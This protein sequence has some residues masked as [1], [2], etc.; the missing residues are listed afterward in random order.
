MQELCETILSYSILLKR[1]DRDGLSV[2]A[3][4]QHC[5]QFLYETLGERVDFDIPDALAKL[6][7]L[8]LAHSDGGG[9]TATRLALAPRVLA[10]NWRELLDSRKMQD[11]SDGYL[12]EDF[13]T[14]T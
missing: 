2:E 5:E 14:A 4:D 12:D 13:F 3:L 6:S 1:A 7:R 8:G 11:S 9:W 10:E